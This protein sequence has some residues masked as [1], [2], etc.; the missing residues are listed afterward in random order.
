MLMEYLPIFIFFVVAVGFALVTLSV[1]ADWTDAWD[2]RCVKAFRETGSPGQP[3]GP[4]WMTEVGRDLTALGGV[5][6]LLLATA[7]VVGFLG[8]SR[9]FGLMTFVLIATLG[10][11]GL[12]SALKAFF[13]RPRPGVVPHL[14]SAHTSSFPSGHSLMSAVVYLTLGVLLATLVNRGRLKAYILAVALI[15]TGLVGVSRVYMGVHYPTD[16]LAGWMT[17]LAWAMLCWMVARWLR[18]RGAVEAAEPPLR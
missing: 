2:A 1:W 8:F 5:A 12:S 7:A 4:A 16:V 15:L 10:G 11:L 18:R 9:K 14:S 13:A 3:I 17:G 6:V